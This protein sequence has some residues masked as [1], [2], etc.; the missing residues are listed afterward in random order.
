MDVSGGLYSLTGW[1]GVLLGCA[2]STTHFANRALLQADSPPDY[3]SWHGRSLR[4]TS[5]GLAVHVLTG[6]APNAGTDTVF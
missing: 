6:A 3:T 1:P 2:T 5:T 4:I